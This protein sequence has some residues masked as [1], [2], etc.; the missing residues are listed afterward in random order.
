VRLSGSATRQL[1][2]QPSRERAPQS[3]EKAS[4]VNFGAQVRRLQ[5]GQA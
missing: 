1:A 2:S 3:G 5:Q 4:T